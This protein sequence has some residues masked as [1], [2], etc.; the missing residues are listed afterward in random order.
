MM[1]L[2]LK[3]LET[4]GESAKEALDELA[5]AWELLKESY[6]EAGEA[7]PTAPTRKKYSGAFN[8]CVDKRVHKALAIE[9][10]QAGVSLNALISQKL[11][12]TAHV[13]Q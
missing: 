5:I 6:T 1:H 2:P 8:V 13:H 11:S 4:L 3:T 10:A 12:A 7:I 9:A